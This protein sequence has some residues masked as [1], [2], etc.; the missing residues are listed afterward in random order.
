MI[1]I[2]IVQAASLTNALRLTS[3]LTSRFILNLHG[4][5]HVAADT[6]AARSD[7]DDLV[8]AR[9]S[10]VSRPFQMGVIASESA[11]GCAFQT[12]HLCSSSNEAVHSSHCDREV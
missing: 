10:G 6:S 11:R 7:S 12:H 3:I 8:F 4:A 9:E 2:S 1:Y 5:N